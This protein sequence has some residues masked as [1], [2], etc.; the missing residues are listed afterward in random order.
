MPTDTV[1]KDAVA[2]VGIGCRTPGADNI[3]DYWRVLVNGE[4]HVCDVPQ[5]R[6]NKDAFYSED[7]SAHCKAY[8]QKG[9]FMKDI[10]GFDNSLY[11]INDIEAGQMDPQQC[12]L[13]DC[14][15]M[16]LQDAGITRKQLSGSSTG[17]Y[18][19]SMN[20]DHRSTSLGMT[21]K[22]GSY[23]ASSSAS[24]FLSCRLSYVFNL[25]GPSMTVDTACSAALVAIHLGRQ[26]ILTGDCDQ[27]ICGGV[28]CMLLPDVFVHLSKAR[29]ISPTGQC[30]TFSDKADG[31]TRGEGCGIVIL[32]RLTAA[33]RDGDHIWATIS[34]GTNQDGR[35]VTPIT[36]PSGEQQK[37]LLHSVYDKFH[38]DLSQLDY[39]E[40]HG[41]GT[42]TGDPVEVNALGSFLKEKGQV[43][44]RYIGSLKTNIGH[45]E[46][47]AGA[48]SVIK[49]CLMM[50]Y[51]T[52][53]PSLHCD[54]VNPSIN[55]TDLK[56]VIPK[57]PV[58]WPAPD[59]LCCCN[60]FGF[61]G[62]NSHAVLQSF[63]KKSVRKGNEDDGSCIVCF[64]GKSITSLKGSLEDFVQDPESSE[65]NV[66]D[67]SYTSTARRDHHL[68]RAAFLVEDTQDLLNVVGQ[69]LSSEDW[70]RPAAPQQQRVVFVFCGMGTSWQ[71]MCRQLLEQH[72]VFRDIL[73]EV[74]KHLSAYV[75][76][77]LTQRLK[78]EDPSKDPLLDPIAIFAC[79]VGLAAVW[80]SLGILPTC[81]VGQSIGE[82]AAAHT[83]GC[84]SL[85]DAV[86][87]I[88]HRSR[89]LA[90]VTD[91]AMIV[92]LNVEVEKV[93]QVLR[94]SEPGASISQEYSSKSCAVS[95]PAHIMPSTKRCLQS[96]LKAVHPGMQIKDLNVRVAYHSAHV[97]QCAEKLTGQ[98]KGLAARPPSLPLQSAV[99]GSPLTT[100]PEA[101]YWATNLREPVLFKQA[102]TG[103]ASGSQ[104]PLF[105][106]IGPRPV[107]KPHLKDLFPSQEV[108]AVPSMLKP[109]EMTTLLK[110][111]IS[112]Y[113]EG[114]D[115]TWSAIPGKGTETTEDPR[116]CFNKKYQ[117]EKTET[118]H[119]VLGGLDFY[120][121]AHLYTCPIRDNTTYFRLMI[122]P[123]VIPS[124]Y[125]HILSGKIIVPGAFLAEASFAVAHY[126][127]IVHP[128]ISIEFE[129]ATAL[130]KGEVADLVA[131][132]DISG[133][134]ADGG[135]PPL[136]IKR[137]NRRLAT[138]QLKETEPSAQEVVN[139]DYIRA[140]CKDVVDKSGI[141]SALHKFGFQYGPAYSLLEQACKS[142][143]ECLVLLKLIDSIQGEIS[144]TNLHP[145]ILDCMLQTS[146][147]VLMEHGNENQVMLPKRMGHL[148]VHQPVQSTM[149][150]YTR[151]KAISTRQCVF[152]MQL[153]S[154]TGQVIADLLDFVIQ[155][156]HTQKQE[157][158]ATLLTTEWS[159]IMDT[160]AFFLK[161]N[162][163]DIH[164]KSTFLFIT[165][166]DLIKN[167][168]H[169]GVSYLNKGDMANVVN[170]IKQAM[171]GQ[172]RSFSGVVLVF[173]TEIDGSTDGNAVQEQVVAMCSLIQAILQTLKD[174]SLNI[175]FYVCTTN[176]WPSA[177]GKPSNTRTN[178][179]A[180]ALWGLLR[181]VI[182]ERVYRSTTAVDLC[183]PS[184]LTNVSL[185]AVFSFL[186]ETEGLQDCPELM[187]TPDG[188]YTNQV[189]K[190]SSSPLSAHLHNMAAAGEFSDNKKKLD[191]NSPLAIEYPLQAHASQQKLVA[192]KV[193]EFLSGADELW[194]GKSVS[195]SYPPTAD[196]GEV[197]IATEMRGFLSD[198]TDA[199]VVC[200]CPVVS[201][202]EVSVPAETVIP[203]SLMPDYELGDLTKL[204]V[205]WELYSNV[206]TQDLT[207]LAST[208]TQNLAEVLKTFFMTSPKET[209]P[210]TVDIALLDTLESSASLYENVIS[211]VYMDEHLASFLT[212]HWQRAEV[213]VT[214][215]SLMSPKAFSVMVSYRSGVKLTLLDTQTLFQPEHL[216]E[217]VPQVQLW[218]K[219]N[220]PRMKD[221]IKTLHTAV[222][223]KAPDINK[224]IQFREHATDAQKG[225]SFTDARFKKDAAY[226]V[227]G[228]L[229]GL[230]WI[231]VELLACRNAGYIAILNRSSPS[232]DQLA[233]MNSLSQ[234]YGCQVQAYQ[235]DI[236]SVE[237]VQQ[238]FHQVASADFQLRGVFMGAAV[239]K[240]SS[241]LAMTRE[242]FHKVLGPKIKGTWNLHQLTKTV[243]LD[244]FV[245]HS[246]IVSVLGNP[247]QANYVVGN[248]FMDGLAW[249]RHHLGL[250]AQTINWGPLDTGLLDQQVVLKQKMESAGFHIP[251]HQEISKTLATVLH[252]K[253]TQSVPARIDPKLYAKRLYSTSSQPLIRR[254]QKFASPTGV[255]SQ[256]LAHSSMQISRIKSLSPEQ[257]YQAY[258]T[259]LT[260]IVSHLLVV[261]VAQVSPHVSLISMGM[262]SMSGTSL[263]DQIRQDTGFTIPAVEVVTEEST[264]KSL[265]KV[266][267]QHA[268]GFAQD[269]KF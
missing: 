94:E 147:L 264:V 151:L 254:F 58:P 106:E 22:V 175:K 10:E 260:E 246:S 189:V 240:D 6:W 37:K 184:G 205:L 93:R 149:Y 208:S 239:L 190:D 256:G 197:V 201:N 258:E 75:P 267:D 225:T 210:Q 96:K 76:W 103:A 244:H 125:D 139:L 17:V 116:Y 179:V 243:P 247:G 228:G 154:P 85:A 214:Y 245:L 24:S 168:G 206:E 69:R 73:M 3:R 133:N 163:S 249:Y 161:G 222:R 86:K 236:T 167:N 262:D 84:F 183:L 25:L 187:V 112:L 34:T 130:K 91:G 11:G 23:T 62:T 13:L 181:T 118:H 135:L 215:S 114:L 41:T 195:N 92:V 144:S 152:D 21:S 111:V 31:Y 233:N 255:S 124:I 107:L 199:E 234:K 170:E 232:A 81:I 259:Y 191:G 14:A 129:H 64:S 83:A 257:R 45:T 88:F 132:F 196:L 219:T 63:R 51:N 42:P 44:Q 16:A 104:R 97:S 136:V 146:A 253:Q 153:V 158:A 61:G 138:A 19:G 52:I 238:V 90:E 48:L 155:F 46:S 99:T 207:I 35:T 126:R 221:Y 173:S 40:A 8:V 38:V 224:L 120:H 101:E 174:L 122:S 231:C 148:A 211:L 60:A 145:S 47:A 182:L 169:L 226:I 166:K 1:D 28:N 80:R 27:A 20:P 71:G 98:L 2:I 159:R 268:G 105:L 137:E 141:Y 121:K 108:T 26:A 65:L 50:K 134:S 150:V 29:M 160:P 248:A 194:N 127:Q 162:A 68:Y 43:R 18:I 89:L 171:A 72:Q 4:C 172:S 220:S 110:A 202:P 143:R 123:L 59:K 95:A 15:S 237:S 218:L 178:P 230:G 212:E 77:S 12:L 113:E 223:T 54:R 180:T 164:G 57:S 131:E 32:K 165:D 128:A 198:K 263:L 119:V 156:L 209:R 82:V 109:P 5:H 235:A 252:L 36:A 186:A 251:G 100:A 229:T 200:C 261:E 157:S 213:F 30:H 33:L 87:I 9:G 102:I 115:I 7:L 241:F 49:L 266:L 193:Q 188:V 39:I 66:H 265:A 74:D 78:T 142:T 53:V 217:T 203:T 117:A 79:Q 177:A 70:P 227:V 140:K 67:V 204:V 55:L 185:P 242:D 176:A 192:L 56:F 250:P 269:T 216:K